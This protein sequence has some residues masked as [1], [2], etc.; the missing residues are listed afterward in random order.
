MVEIGGRDW[1]DM[2]FFFASH[3]GGF[4]PHISRGRWRQGI[5]Q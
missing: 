4:F 2:G 3:T 1:L 5:L